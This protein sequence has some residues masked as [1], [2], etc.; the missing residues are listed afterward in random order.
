MGSEAA[1]EPPQ[2]DLPKKQKLSHEE[3]LS[4]ASLAHEAIAAG[5]VTVQRIAPG[6]GGAAKAKAWKRRAK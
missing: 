3:R 1:G 4:L 2:R 6:R 5:A